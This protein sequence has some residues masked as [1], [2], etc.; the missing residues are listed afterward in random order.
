EFLE[1]RL[2]EYREIMSR[3]HVEGRDLIA[4]GLAP[5]EYFGELL[6]FAHKLRLAGID[7]ESALK[8]T[9]A[10]ARKMKV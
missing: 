7:R 1:E 6:D 9:L 4:A 5:G 8:Q 2:A 10:M 3:P